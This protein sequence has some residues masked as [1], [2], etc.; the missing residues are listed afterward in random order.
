[1]KAIETV[2]LDVLETKQPGNVKE[3]VRLVQKQAD[4]SLD[5][6]KKEVKNLQRKGLVAL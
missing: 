4:A 3:L 5:A 2:I 6:I 1:M